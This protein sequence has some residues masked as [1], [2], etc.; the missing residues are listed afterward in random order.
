MRR[1]KKEIQYRNRPSAP[2]LVKTVSKI[3][4]GT[5]MT[6]EQIRKKK[7]KLK[8]IRKKLRRVN[9]IVQKKIRKKV[10]KFGKR[11]IVNC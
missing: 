2:P 9:K 1:E 10:W 11:K 8:K 6:L 5:K 4:F 3:K 7:N